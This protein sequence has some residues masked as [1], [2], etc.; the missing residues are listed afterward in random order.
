M[1]DAKLESIVSESIEKREETNAAPNTKSASNASSFP[2][3][4]KV[5]H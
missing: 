1:T 2:V 4:I 3:L 5:R